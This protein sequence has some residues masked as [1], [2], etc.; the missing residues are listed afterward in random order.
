MDDG[1]Q[2]AL[3]ED[4]KIWRRRAR[5][6]HYMYCL[7]FYAYSHD[8]GA[9]LFRP[10]GTLPRSRKY[11]KKQLINYRYNVSLSKVNQLILVLNVESYNTILILT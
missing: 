10:I 6:P 7:Y 2:A 8:R 3:D 9:L 1:S 5:R 11:F 4:I